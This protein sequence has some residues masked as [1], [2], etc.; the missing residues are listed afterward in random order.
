MRFVLVPIQITPAATV[1]GASAVI[2]PPAAGAPTPPL[3]TAAGSGGGDP[4]GT[5][6]SEL[7]TR[8]VT[9][10]PA[11]AR[12]CW[13]ARYKVWGSCGENASGGAPPNRSSGVG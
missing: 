12:T 10:R 1:D 9:P 8:H 5:A 11:E 2:D 7:I 6:R 4:G 3:P 13:A